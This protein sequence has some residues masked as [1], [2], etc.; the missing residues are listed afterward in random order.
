M[1]KTGNRHYCNIYTQ[2]RLVHKYLLSAT[3][4]MMTEKDIIT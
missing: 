3:T 1:V 2:V 4:S